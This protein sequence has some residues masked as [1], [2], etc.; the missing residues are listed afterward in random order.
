MQTM[1]VVGVINA[2]GRLDDRQL[3]HE[4]DAR[5]TAQAE[6]RSRRNAELPRKTNIL[7]CRRELSVEVVETGLV[8]LQGILAK[9][10]VGTAIEKQDG[11]EG[12]PDDRNPV[13]D[14]SIALRVA[15]RESDGI[16][17][18]RHTD[19]PLGGLAESVQTRSAGV[20][21]LLRRGD[22][23][24]SD[25]SDRADVKSA[26]VR[27]TAHIKAA[28]GRRLPSTVAGDECS[29]SVKTDN[30]AALVHRMV[31]LPIDDVG[32]ALDVAAETRKPERVEVALSARGVD[33]IVHGVVGD[34]RRDGARNDAV[35]R[36][37][38]GDAA[39]LHL[40]EQELRSI[41]ESGDV[42]AR[43][44]ILQADSRKR[45]FSDGIAGKERKAGAVLIVVLN[46]LR[47][48]ADGLTGEERC[49]PSLVKLVTAGK[50]REAGRDRAVK[51]IGFGESEQEAARKVAELR[52]KSKSFAETQE[53]VGLIGKADEAAGQ[54]TDTALQA[55]RL[56]TLFLELEVD[57]NR[58]FF[59]VALDLRGLVGFDFVEVIELIEAQDAE[60]PETLIEELALVD[61]QLAANDL[62]ARGG[63]AAEVDAPDEIL[64]LFVEP[65]GQVDDFIDVVNFG[66][67]LG[68]EIDESIFA[69]DF[70]VGFQSLRTFSVEKISPCLRGNAAFNASTLRDSA[71][72]GSELTILSVPIWKRSPS[73]M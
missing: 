25:R 49:L 51:E 7:R 21:E 36:A 43:E 46:E 37:G 24:E 27:L 10:A 47:V 22:R 12:V 16:A 30:V 63:V 58:T 54:T 14:V 41:V 61:H 31:V 8:E 67:R 29:R 35:Q 44:S 5:R 9:D 73:S 69:V 42:R 23:Y 71:L 28:V 66:V 56:F 19:G 20:G 52:G 65:Q 3:H 18:H 38:T 50:N 11:L 40:G 34:R 39:E 59:I 13:L 45:E 2:E 55:D 62:V 48:D 33:R 26:N 64:L 6:V 4:L 57:V 60:L 68:S 53:V 70:P 17:E 15:T 1:D 72:S 32:D